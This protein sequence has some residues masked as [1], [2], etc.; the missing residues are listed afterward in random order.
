MTPEEIKNDQEYQKMMQAEFE[1]IFARWLKKHP[2]IA[3]LNGLEKVK[4]ICRN[5]FELG[6]MHY[7]AMEDE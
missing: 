5:W 1:P 2:E 7:A 6:A 3:K 4:D